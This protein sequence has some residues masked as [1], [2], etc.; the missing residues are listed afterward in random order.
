MKTIKVK[1]FIQALDQACFDIR[2]LKS[3]LN[4][5]RLSKSEKV[6]ITCFLHLRDNQIQL[7]IDSLTSLVTTDQLVESQKNL[8]LGSAYNNKSLYTQALPYFIKAQNQMEGFD[9]PKLEFIILSN[10]FILHFNMKDSV[11]MYQVLQMMHAHPISHG[12]GKVSLYRADFNYYSFIGDYPRA[13]KGLKTLEIMKGE[14]SEGHIIS[15]LTNKFGYFIK[16]DRYEECEKTLKEMKSYR[17]FNLT[18][19]YNFMKQL[20]DHF[21]SNKTLYIDDADY[22]DFPILLY[23]VKVVQKLE[24]GDYLKAREFW[25]KLAIDY[26]GS[27]GSN[28]MDYTGDKCIFSLCLKKYE[29]VNN[30]ER[31]TFVGLPG[32]KEQALLKILTE[33]QVPIQQ[34]HI[35]EMIW[36]ETPESKSDF[37]KLVQLIY[38]LKKKTG[39]DIKSRKNCYYIGPTKK[40]KVS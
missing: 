34:G 36:K 25:D 21:V 17:K 20:L 22:K 35:Y 23:Q 12:L 10:L 19:N 30:L 3:F 37:N 9:L 18:A 11:S 1:T 6:I 38:S 32:N 27:H 33:A 14:M 16:R 15:Y 13:E 24:E 4:D 28:F 8:L 7:T 5:K 31:I 26:P 2:K 29:N 40:E 39:I